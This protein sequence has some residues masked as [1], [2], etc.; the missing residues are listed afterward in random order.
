[1]VRGSIL[2][3]VL[4]HVIKKGGKSITSKGTRMLVRKKIWI[5]RRE[6]FPREL[7]IQI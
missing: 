2:L 1:M 5:D 6:M 4:M 3:R 7:G